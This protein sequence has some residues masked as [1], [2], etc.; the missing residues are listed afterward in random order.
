MYLA[1]TPNVLKSVHG[2]ISVIIMPSVCSC[3]YVEYRI[4]KTVGFISSDSKYVC[5]VYGNALEICFK[6]NFMLRNLF[7]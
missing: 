5:D 4:Y 1:S 3:D 2:Y 7:L 6:Y